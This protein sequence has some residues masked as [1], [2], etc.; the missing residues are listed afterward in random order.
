[1]YGPTVTAVVT[2]GGPAPGAAGVGGG[3]INGAPG[4]AVWREGPA[5]SSPVLFPTSACRNVRRDT[6]LEDVVDGGGEGGAR[7]TA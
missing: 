3:A 1:M 4:G 7:T 6:G 5:I 2:A